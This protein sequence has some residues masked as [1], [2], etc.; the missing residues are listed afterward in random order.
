MCNHHD[1]SGNQLLAQQLLWGKGRSQGWEW[2][3]WDIVREEPG[4]ILG[5]G[6]RGTGMQGT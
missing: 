3:P 6:F 1:L 5:W 4:P 2:E